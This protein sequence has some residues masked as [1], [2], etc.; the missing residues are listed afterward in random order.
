MLD[1]ITDQMWA[2]QVDLNL[3]GKLIIFPCRMTVVRLKNG[4]VLLHSPIRIDDALAAEI[5]AIG[6]VRY[7]IAPNCFHHL[8]LTDV[9]ARYPEAKLY[10]A[11]GLAQKRPDLDVTAEIRPD[12]KLPWADE[13]DWFALAGA[14]KMNE[15][16]LLHRASKTLMVTDLMFNMSRVRGP[17]TPFLLLCAGAWRKP[18]QSRVWRLLTRDR[19]AAKA[20]LQP[21]LAQNFDRVTMAHGDVVAQNGKEVFTQALH[22]MLA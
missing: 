16:I 17:M 4:D 9:M 12:K 19:K 13:F 5:E 22:W 7:L 3:V 14:P 15:I 1:P 6:P 2:A 11:P 10:T 20:S 18:G 21:V 8:Y